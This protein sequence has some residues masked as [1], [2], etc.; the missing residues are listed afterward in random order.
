M[1]WELKIPK[2]LHVY[3]GGRNL[4]FLRYLT[5]TTFMR[6]NPD[7][8][9]RFYYPTHP[10][11]NTSWFTPEN[12]HAEPKTNFVEKL[13]Q[14]P[15]TKI[16]VDFTQYGFSNDLS[17]VHKSDILRIHLLS[18]VGGLW[19]DMDIFYFK[20]MSWF[21]L[22]D[23]KNSHIETFYCNREYGH[24]IGFLMASEGNK[25]FG[26]LA[27]T[28]KDNYNAHYYQTFGAMMFNKYFRA[29]GNIEAYT[30]AI[31]I[32]MDVVYSHVAGN[33]AQLLEPNRTPN[34][35][36]R[37]IGI[38]W[39]GG[40]EVWKNFLRDTDGGLHDVPDCIIGDL[41]KQYKI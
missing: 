4:S 23:K 25:F 33:T 16:P 8:E 24:S 20:P 7:W 28:L 11:I 1:D 38:H 17:E 26:I 34:F 30:P 22:N 39:Y 41:L 29:E 21:Y 15:I 18:T 14:L 19:S 12:K 5:V 31:N 6:H 27:G 40:D 37:S 13:M 9:I 10:T 35:T 32:A 36:Y 2:I 3:W